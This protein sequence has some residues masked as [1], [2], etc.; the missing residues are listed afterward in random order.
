MKSQFFGKDPDAGEDRRQKEKRVAEDEMVRQHHQ[1][2]R[3]E[4]EQS[5]GA[6]ASAVTAAS[7]TWTPRGSSGFCCCCCFFFNWEIWETPFQKS[8]NSQFS[9]VR[10]CD[11]MD[12]S[13]PDS[14]L[15]GVFQA[16]ILEWAAISFSKGVFLKQGLNPLL[17]W[18]VD[19]LPL[20]HL[21]S[22]VHI[23]T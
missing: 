18:Q 9:Y 4:S 12:C 19:S 10:F 21:G 13:P 17:H 20:K 3:H 23:H 16:R 15:H 7:P 11:T 2:N 5:L 22:P 6:Q 8:E 1:L 14:S